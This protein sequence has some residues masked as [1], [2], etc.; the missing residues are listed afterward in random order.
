[1]SGVYTK[2]G[3]DARADTLIGFRGLVIPETLRPY[4]RGLW[5]PGADNLSFFPAGYAG[6]KSVADYSFAGDIENQYPLTNV[7]VT[8][9]AKGFTSGTSA[10]YQAP[11]TGAQL[12]AAGT[13]NEVSLACVIKANP[14]GSS[15]AISCYNGSTTPGFGLG[16]ATG[17]PNANY[18][19]TIAYA[20]G[21]SQT[22]QIPRDSDTGVVYEYLGAGYGTTMTLYR[23]KPGQ[24]SL[25][26]ASS[27]PT[28]T[29]VPGGAS[30]LRLGR[31]VG[32][33][34]TTALEIVAGVCLTKQLSQA[35]FQA[36]QV[37]LK[38]Y[39]FNYL[40]LTI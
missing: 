2:G 9:S 7:G 40:N 1:M 15:A 6:D 29:G 33:Q 28:L 18:Q 35:E 34:M 36:L 17:S 20:S 23:Q 24:G 12:A 30:N 22:L 25:T 14:T 37:A 11:F 39:C 27:P 8:P 19:A 31:S 4:T 32:S 16:L 10:Y 21:S 3:G 38:N 5:L 13:A 26:P